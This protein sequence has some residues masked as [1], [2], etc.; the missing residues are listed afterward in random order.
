MVF[1]IALHQRLEGLLAT[2][3]DTG[4]G[5]GAI[6]IEVEQRLDVELGADSR[7]GRGNAAT[8]AQ[9]LE[10]DDREQTIHEPAGLTCPFGELLGREPAIALVDGLVSEQALCDRGELGVDRIELEVGILR[11]NVLGD[12]LDGAIGAAVISLS[13]CRSRFL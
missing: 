13:D 12:L 5:K 3:G 9:V 6:E 2:T 10:L 11:P 8:A 7:R 4:K 1:V